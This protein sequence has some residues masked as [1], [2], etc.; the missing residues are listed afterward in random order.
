MKEIPR[1]ED[2]SKAKAQEFYEGDFYLFSLGL[3][4]LKPGHIDV[5]PTG[6]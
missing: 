6:L 3:I 4:I 2:I 5:V 1:E